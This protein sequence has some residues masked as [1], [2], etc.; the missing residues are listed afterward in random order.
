VVK[1]S[2]QIRNH[3]KTMVLD[4]AKLFL[5]R[6]I[7]VD[8]YVF[9]D[10]ACVWHNPPIIHYDDY[11]AETSGGGREE[12]GDVTRDIGADHWAYYGHEAILTRGS[13][14]SVFVVPSASSTSAVDSKALAHA[15]EIER[16]EKLVSIYKKAL[17]ATGTVEDCSIDPLIPY[18]Y[19]LKEEV[20]LTEAQKN[21]LW[22][23]LH[24]ELF[25]RFLE[26]R[27]TMP[28][29]AFIGPDTVGVVFCKADGSHAVI[30]LRWS[31]ALWKVE[32]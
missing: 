11:T 14:D 19:L 13:S 29:L 24:R 2:S 8:A 22:H 30:K 17:N 15:N 31:G 26:V 4:E 32:D 5:T 1:K 27:D 16:R 20:P 28:G 3:Q 18:L 12:V 23:V 6:V 9:R 21:N 25:P 10:G 7:G